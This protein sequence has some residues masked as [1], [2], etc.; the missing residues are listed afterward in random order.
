[1]WKRLDNKYNDE[2][3]LVD[4]IM[5]EIKQLT[6]DSGNPTEILQMIKVIERAHRDLKSLDLEDEISNSIIVSM[7]EERLPE[8]IEK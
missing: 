6:S 7:I 8:Q 1:M 2:S 3:K 4:S 5:A